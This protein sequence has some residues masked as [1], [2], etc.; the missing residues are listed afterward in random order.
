MS[1]LQLDWLNSCSSTS[2]ILAFTYVSDVEAVVVYYILKNTL[3]LF[4]NGM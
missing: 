4:L 1:H 2:F 3:L